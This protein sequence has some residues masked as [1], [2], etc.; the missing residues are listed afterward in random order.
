MILTLVAYMVTILYSEID[1]VFKIR[2]TKCTAMSSERTSMIEV[3]PCEK[4]EKSTKSYE[5][6]HRYLK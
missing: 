4:Q 5:E 2:C 3:Y 6:K 1:K